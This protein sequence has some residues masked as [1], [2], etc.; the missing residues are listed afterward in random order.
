MYA[1]EF[2]GRICY[3]RYSSHKRYANLDL[4][5]R[6]GRFRNSPHVFDSSIAR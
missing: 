5:D 3:R 1:A 2:G 6:I 4:I